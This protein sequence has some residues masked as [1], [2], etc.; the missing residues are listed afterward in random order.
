[1]IKEHRVSC[2]QA[3]KAVNLPKSTYNY[4]PKAKDDAQVI[5][6]LNQLVEKHP[7]IGFWQSFYRIRRQGYLWNHKRVYRV[8]T[9]MKLNIRRRYRKRLPSRIKQALFQPCSI[10][11]AW[12]ID[13]LSVILWV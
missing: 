9:T 4:K 13:F 8:Y 3:C 7:A 5:E 12:M 10:N 6:Q 11:Q 1:M 2:R